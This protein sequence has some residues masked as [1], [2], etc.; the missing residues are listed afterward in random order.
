RWRY[1]KESFG[2]GRACPGHPRLS[3]PRRG[4]PVATVLRHYAPPG[5]LDR[6]VKPAMTMENDREALS[7]SPVQSDLVGAQQLQLQPLDRWDLEPREHAA[8]VDEVGCDRIDEDEVK[9]ARALAVRHDEI[10]QN[11]GEHFA[12]KRVEEIV[13]RLA[14][15]R[16]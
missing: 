9:P 6:P 11:L 5:S 2:H 12:R 1:D 16:P 8:I 13:H 7:E 3:C 10:M 14:L 15:G 4:H